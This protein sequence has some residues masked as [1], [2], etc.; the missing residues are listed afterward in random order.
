M[1]SWFDLILAV[2]AA[3]LLYVFKVEDVPVSK[4]EGAILG[5]HVHHRY[6]AVDLAPFPQIIHSILK[7]LTVFEHFLYVFSDHVVYY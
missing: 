6:E 2:K 7:C 4:L 5:S 1:G 3:E